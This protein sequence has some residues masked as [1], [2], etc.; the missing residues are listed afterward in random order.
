MK[1]DDLVTRATE[2]EI[3]E[4]VSDDEY[5]TQLEEDLTEAVDL[6]ETCHKVLRRITKS[7]IAPESKFVKNLMTD[8]EDFILSVDLESVEEEK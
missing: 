7:G 8:I 3:E 5:D 2:P 1:L 6:L 4:E